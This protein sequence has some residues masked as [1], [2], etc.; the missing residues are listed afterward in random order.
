[1]SGYPEEA[2]FAESILE[3]VVDNR[4]R[5]NDKVGLTCSHSTSNEAALTDPEDSAV[6]PDNFNVLFRISDAPSDFLQILSF[7]RLS[8]SL[9]ISISPVLRSSIVG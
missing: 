5:I 9:S 1:L 8:S 4:E 6:T 2:A 3:W 7:R